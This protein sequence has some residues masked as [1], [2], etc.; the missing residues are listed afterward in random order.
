VLTQ[1]KLQN[2]YL[3][4]TLDYFKYNRNEKQATRKDEN[5]KLNNKLKCDITAHLIIL[6]KIQPHL[7]NDRAEAWTDIKQISGLPTWQNNNCQN[8]P[9]YTISSQLNAI[10]YF[11]TIIYNQCIDC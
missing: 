1:E 7:V 10:F 2:A 8:E 3:P 5:R 4:K 6:K 11:G 9:I